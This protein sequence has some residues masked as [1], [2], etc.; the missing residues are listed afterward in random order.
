MM[1]PIRHAQLDQ[2]AAGYVTME[3]KKRKTSGLEAARWPLELAQHQRSLVTG[4]KPAA[5]IAGF[6]A[7]QQGDYWRRE[8]GVAA[9]AS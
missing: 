4:K 7:L 5:V 2:L 8:V 1:I 9:E 3:G 6:E